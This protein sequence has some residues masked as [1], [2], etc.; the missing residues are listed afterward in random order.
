MRNK[1]LRGDCIKAKASNY[2]TT[3]Y[4]IKTE[5]HGKLLVISFDKPEIKVNEN[6]LMLA[7][8]KKVVHYSYKKF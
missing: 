2:L 3:L 1:E 8:Y 4:S 7:V 5:K 6:P